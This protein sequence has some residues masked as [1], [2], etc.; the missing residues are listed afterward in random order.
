MGEPVAFPNVKGHS[1]LRKLVM[2]GGI[3]HHRQINNFP[4][5]VVS[6]DSLSSK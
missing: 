4:T 6:A 3:D 5:D 2:V 1:R